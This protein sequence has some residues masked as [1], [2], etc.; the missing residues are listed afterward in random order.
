MTGKGRDSTGRSSQLS[1]SPAVETA[2]DEDSETI[3]ADAA[4]FASDTGPA[5]AANNGTAAANKV[6]L[7]HMSDIFKLISSTGTSFIV[8]PPHRGRPSRPIVSQHRR[9]P[10]K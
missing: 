4:L 9:L 10:P 5:T 1:I 8:V 3:L 7:R 2:L 6:N